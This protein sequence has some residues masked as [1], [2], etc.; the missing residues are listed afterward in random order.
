MPVKER[1]ADQ[2]KHVALEGGMVM[3]GH[4]FIPQMSLSCS[5]LLVFI[6]SFLLICTCFQDTHTHNVFQI[7]TNKHIQTQSFQDTRTHM[8]TMLSGST[9]TMFSRYSHRHTMLSGYTHT[10]AFLSTVPCGHRPI[11]FF[12]IDGSSQRSLTT[13][14]HMSF[15]IFSAATTF[16][17]VLLSNL[18]QC[19]LLPCL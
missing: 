1:K 10:H 4:L 15:F 8:H 2:S 6:W 13:F 12:V 16:C 9:Q 3:S 14:F 17:Y 11:H 18:W 19:W 7:Q 5:L